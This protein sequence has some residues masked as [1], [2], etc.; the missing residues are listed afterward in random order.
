MLKKCCIYSIMFFVLIAFNYFGIEAYA[1]TNGNTP[2]IISLSFDKSQVTMNGDVI[3]TMVIE[4][5]TE[6]KLDSAKIFNYTYVSIKNG[7][8][9]RIIKFEKQDAGIYTAKIHI[10][11]NYTQG[12][13]IIDYVN[14][15][16][17]AGNESATFDYQYLGFTVYTDLELYSIPSL[18]NTYVVDGKGVIKDISING[19]LFIAPNAQIKL[20]NINV[21]GD[22]FVYGKMIGKNSQAESIHAKK[23][24]NSSDFMPSKN[25]EAALYNNTFSNEDISSNYDID[26]IPIRIDNVQ[27]SNGKIYISGIMA[28]VADLYFNNILI[29]VNSDGKFVINQSYSG[30]LDTVSFEFRT[31]F[32]NKT[33]R[34]F[35]I[36]NVNDSKGFAPIIY[37]FDE[38]I[39]VDSPIKSSDSVYAYD[40]EDGVIEKSITLDISNVE[41]KPGTYVATYH[42]QDSDGN[43]SEKD[44]NITIRNHN[45]ELAGYDWEN[46]G[47]KCVINRVCSFDKSHEISNSMIVTSKTIKDEGINI[48]SIKGA[49]LLS[50][51]DDYREFIQRR[52]RILRHYTDEYSGMEKRIANIYDV[53]VCPSS[54]LPKIAEIELRRFYEYARLA[55]NFEDCNK[56]LED[57]L[58]QYNLDLES[59][60][61]AESEGVEVELDE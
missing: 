19:D 43:I 31:V 1:E 13:Y 59:I 37:A 56:L 17:K 27:L 41:N 26:Y 33:T 7:D 48:P 49:L 14:I 11:E 29:N 30:D 28:K 55:D 6:L 25:G 39:C 57:L 52:G 22:I 32:K 23:I 50:S 51:N 45:Y 12:K 61:N 42:C 44:I 40:K 58:F 9:S 18:D 53:I 35:S 2:R 36:N 47:S 20:Y 4:G 24:Y 34:S 8:D 16:D 46:D 54:D 21:T 3:L 5:D 38:T 15:L 60:T 10:Y